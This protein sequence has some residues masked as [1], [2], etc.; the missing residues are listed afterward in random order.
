MQGIIIDFDNIAQNS[1]HRRKLC[2]HVVILVRRKQLNVTFLRLKMDFL[3]HL[4]RNATNF[5]NQYSHNPQHGTTYVR[6]IKKEKWRLLTCRLLRNIFCIM[7]WFLEHDF[8]LQ[9]QK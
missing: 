6:T 3:L 2:P 5:P 4:T 9:K 7:H 1:L 8:K